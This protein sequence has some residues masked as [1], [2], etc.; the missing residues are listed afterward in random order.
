MNDRNRC[1]PVALA[2]NKPVSESIVPCTLTKSLALKQ[3]YC[4]FNGL[5]SSKAIE[6]TGVNYHS[7]AAGCHKRHRRVILTG[8]DNCDY[9]QLHGLSE[10]HVS[11][12]VSWDRHDGS[13]SIVSKHVV[14]CPDWYFF[15]AERIYGI[16]TEEDS[17][18]FSVCC[19]AINVCG[20]LGLLQIREEFHPNT[21]FGFGSQFARK[22][23][24]SG[25]HHECGAI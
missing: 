5:I 14:G 6:F 19:Q 23:R 18:L 10:T 24:I 16:A 7:I 13:G 2:R 3:L 17:R 25:Y 21:R 1:S 11:F 20:L 12:I 4:L 22:I 15:T 9:W 8:V